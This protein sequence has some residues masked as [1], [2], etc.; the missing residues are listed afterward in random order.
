MTHT[1][2]RISRLPLRRLV[3]EVLCTCSAKA[4]RCASAQVS[5][6]V[7]APLFGMATSFNHLRLLLSRVAYP[8]L[9]APPCPALAQRGS[10]SHV[11]QCAA[12]FYGLGVWEEMALTLAVC[13]VCVRGTASSASLSTECPCAR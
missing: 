9:T 3:D 1:R 8:A 2:R 13:L 4:M 5:S 12:S 7:C 11:L 10:S 6:D